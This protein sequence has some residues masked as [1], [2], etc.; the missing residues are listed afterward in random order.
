M[1]QTYI[2]ITLLACCV[3]YGQNLNFADPNFKAALVTTLCVD[4]NGNWT[5]DTDADTNNDGEIQPDEA[6]A[7]THLIIDNATITSIEGIKRFTNLQNFSCRNTMIT[8]ADVSEMV[9]LKHI[10]I[11]LNEQLSVLNIN[12]LSSLE[13]LSCTNNDLTGVDASNTTAYEFGFS[14]NP[15]LRHI[16]IRNNVHTDCITFPKDGGDYTCAMFLNLPSLRKVCLDDSEME[17]GYGSDFPQ[18]NVQFTTDCFFSTQEH[19]LALFRAYPNPAGS[20]LWLESV[21]PITS[22]T[23]HNNLGQAILFHNA[24][25]IRSID[26]ASLQA[27]LY[28]VQ[29]A[30]QNGTS[31]Q[32]IIK[33]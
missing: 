27:G 33:Q 1:K 28:I 23:V 5:G 4:T 3:G 24:E 31:A 32:K 7:V 2:F 10:R 9:T 19:S 6:L 15:N 12:G 17:A 14:G 18:E 13:T 25:N 11:D 8:S 20:M 22:V 29:V 30:T 21:S 26:V 16:N